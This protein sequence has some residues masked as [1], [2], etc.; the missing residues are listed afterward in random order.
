MWN[1]KISEGLEVSQLFKVL[2]RRRGSLT[3]LPEGRNEVSVF[4]LS[5][6]KVLVSDPFLILLIQ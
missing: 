4:F 6:V 1:L 3:S 2:S 5:L